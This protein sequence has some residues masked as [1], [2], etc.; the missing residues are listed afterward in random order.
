M[1][2][3]RHHCACTAARATSDERIPSPRFGG[4]SDPCQHRC[5]APASHGRHRPAQSTSHGLAQQH[6][7]SFVAHTEA[8]TAGELPRFVKD[9][10]DA[11]L[12]CG[13]QA[14]GFLRLRCGACGRDRPLAF[15]CKQR[16]FGRSCGA[17]RMSQTV[18]HLVDHVIPH[19][20]VRQWMLV[21]DDNA[22]AAGCG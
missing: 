7:A 18:A 15:S 13:I 6:A 12:E 5:D 19:V 8:S 14:R 11:F 10:S 21:V 9:G 17:R 22:D 4:D 16:V 20:P 2:V 3:N 1:D